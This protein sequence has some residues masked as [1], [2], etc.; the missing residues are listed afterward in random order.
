MPPYRKR[1]RRQTCC[2]PRHHG[3]RAGTRRWYGMRAWLRFGLVAAIATVLVSPGVAKRHG[4]SR[5]SPTQ[6]PHKQSDAEIE[7]ATQLQVF[8]DRANFS[9]GKIDGHYNDFTLKALALYRQSRGESVPP[10]SPK[11][12]TVPDLTGIDLATVHPVFIQYTVTDA[13]IKNIGP[14]P[15]GQSTA[16]AA[17][18]AKLPALPYRDVGQEIAEKFHVDEKFL[19]QLN[20]DKNGAILKAG[21]E[22]NVPNVEPFDLDA[23]KNLK[24]GSEL[25][26]DAANEM[27]DEPDSG[28]PAGAVADSVRIKVDVKT[29]MLGVFEGEKIVAAYPVTIGSSNIPTPIG[30]W[31]VRGVVKL[32][33]FRYDERML[34]RGKRSRR[35][36]ILRPGPNNPVGVIWIALNKRGIGIH[37]TDEPDTIGHG[38]SHGCIRL[39]NWDVVRLA[40]RVKAGVPV[41]V[42]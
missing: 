3:Q 19:G 24:P 13:D 38:V 1:H 15:R 37:G 23:V 29:K 35:F 5:P 42:H 2:Y 9:P 17:E 31:K 14:V 12:D 27:P 11:P 20:P 8:L 16:V 6:S 28:S 21:D 40:T 33:T 36:Y 10:P 4:R 18:K 30:E 39:A 26:A 41:S 7:E 22:V 25:T 34:N 32:P